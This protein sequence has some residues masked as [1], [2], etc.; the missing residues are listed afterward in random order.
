MINKKAL[1]VDIYILSSLL[2][3]KYFKYR[4]NKNISLVIF[5]KLC[6]L[7]TKNQ[8]EIE[9]K[10]NC[11]SL[12]KGSIQSDFP[13]SFKNNN[14][15]AE[16]YTNENDDIFY[17]KDDYEVQNIE[18]KRKDKIVKNINDMKENKF[19]NNNIYVQN[20]IG[21]N[22]NENIIKKNDAKKDFH[23]NYK[24]KNIKDA[25]IINGNGIQF[26]Q[27]QTNNEIE[28]K[29]LKK[30]IKLLII[31]KINIE[32]FKTI[33]EFSKDKREEKKNI[34]K[35]LI[36]DYFQKLN[37]LIINMNNNIEIGKNYLNKLITLICALF[38]F[39]T[40]IQKE[41]ILKINIQ[42]DIKDSLKND[43]LFL[44]LSKENNNDIIF[45]DIILPTSDY[46]KKK[47]ELRI[48][49]I[50]NNFFIDSLE[51]KANILYAYKL[52]LFYKMIYG[53]IR[54]NPKLKLLEFKI[55]FILTNYKSF[56]FSNDE[57]INIYKELL[58]IK[59]FYTTIYENEIKEPYIIDISH[60]NIIYGEA[61]NKDNKY[62]YPDLNIL[63]DE[64]INEIY[65]QIMDE[66]GI[67]SNFYKIDY[68]NAKDLVDYSSF[69]IKQF[70]N[71][72]L[73]NIV[74]LVNI[75]NYYI[76]NNF[77]KYKKN[78]KNLEEEI[79]L[80]GNK[81]LTNN[82]SKN[83]ISHYCLK[84]DYEKIFQEF[85]DKLNYYMMPKY[86]NK[87]K[88]FPFGSL[89]EFLSIEKS[90]IDIYLYLEEKFNPEEK[91]EIF[92]YIL[93]SCKK[94]SSI[95]KKVISARICVITLKFDEYEIDLSI[96]GFS[97]YIHSLLFREYSLIDVRFPLIAIALKNYVKIA[98]LQKEY[99]LNS[100]CWMSLLVA[101]L[102]DI[103]EPPVLPKL[104]SDN[105]INEIIYK[106]IE[107][108]NYKKNR[109]KKNEENSFSFLLFFR[110]I[111]K[112]DIPIP[113][114][115]FKKDKIIKICQKFYKRNKD[116][117]GCEKNDL[118]CSEL[119]LKFLE[120][121]IYYKF[122][123]IYANCSIE[124]EGFFNMSEI[125]YIENNKNE[126]EICECKSFYN[127]FNKKY[128]K[129]KD[130]YSKKK[131]RNGLIL[132]RDP[133]DP[134]YNPAQKFRIIEDLEDFM[135]IIRYSY[136]N[137]I[138]YGSFEKLKEKIEKKN[139]K[140]KKENLNNE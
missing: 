108:G 46:N 99:F 115:L 28:V 100:F 42:D 122:D 97:P 85:S 116:K 15:E 78:L 76:K 79:F 74:S 8:K 83:K 20:N 104:F 63:F 69:F 93:E 26:S 136:S 59:E 4:K 125:K 39:L 33:K 111:K 34:A 119:F 29:S 88:L 66:D 18:I 9:F 62:I 123:T 103:I 101:F 92:I 72:F 58:F 114:C 31:N 6:K 90:D 127:Y 77:Q 5:N 37:Q 17:K 21:Y 64:N 56:D 70:K 27:K 75:K 11:I 98:N 32:L 16:S 49:E 36:E 94:F 106:K 120:F 47:E 135:N 73:D 126:N 60:P 10:N 109:I 54:E 41:K 1:F 134:H 44:N 124:K 86:K 140:R 89:T 87:Y 57:Y 14:I 65:S 128:I 129:F 2:I 61:K 68:S 71:D 35:K 81:C 13:N 55:K 105:E 113:D 45:N 50:V 19:I 53:K 96:T 52:I 43:L 95:D 7:K 102:Q 3:K 117:Y 23:N 24:S 110:S 67:I 80:I 112:E 22:K 25:N 40:E 107:F 51:Q 131:I 91:Y 121:M 138:K 30:I 130:I 132:I 139:E 38:P 133:I 118:T 12:L 84:K 82:K 137:L 48:K